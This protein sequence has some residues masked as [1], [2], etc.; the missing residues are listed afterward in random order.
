M[1]NTQHK[2]KY[3]DLIMA[4]FVTILLCSNL[5]GAEKVVTIL[6]F[7]FGAGILFFPI[8]YFFNDILTE[9][10]G[11][12]R[13]RK[14]VWAGFAALGFASFMAWVVIKLPPAQGWIY[15]EA[16]ETVFGQ[17]W[18]IVLAS[19]LAFFSGE[20][21]NSYVLAKMKLFTRGK[22]L[23]TRTI[24]STIAGEMIDSII[25]YPI[26]FYG[27]WPNDL[28]ITVM[29]TNYILK[30]SWEVIAT[31]VTYKVVNFLKKK[32]HEDYYDRDTNFTPFSIT[33]D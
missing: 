31:P 5:I 7:S 9:V 4:A 18:R 1:S 2:Y 3:Y 8:S 12:A 29:I 30:V 23:W 13:S 10:Y 25:F 22:F 26:A 28:L 24:G 16:Y 17:T 19:L 32:E 11:Y 14:V 6:G 15:Q 20:F 33:V 27:F 21:V